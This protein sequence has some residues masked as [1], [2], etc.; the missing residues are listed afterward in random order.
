MEPA[1]TPT[2]KTIP[3]RK[4]AERH[5]A[6]GG[7]TVRKG[8]PTIFALSK[9]RTGTSALLISCG[10]HAK[11]EEPKL[12]ATT[13]DI[14]PAPFSAPSSLTRST[15]PTKV[16]PIAA[17]RVLLSGLTHALSAHAMRA[18]ATAKKALKSR[19]SRTLSCDT[20]TA[21]AARVGRECHD[22]P[23]TPLPTLRTDIGITL[24]TQREARAIMPPR[25]IRRAG[26]CI[27]FY[28]ALTRPGTTRIAYG[29]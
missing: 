18:P 6:A 9:G 23:I 17:M 12:L 19:S 20:P 29:P 16:P 14:T 10:V 4:R 1:T 11:K 8:R 24:T 2:S 25:V 27:H 28:N 5:G 21:I 22:V 3:A 7:I 13:R 26:L 15:T